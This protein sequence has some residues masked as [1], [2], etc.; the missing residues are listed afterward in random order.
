MRQTDEAPS[1]RTRQAS[2]SHIGSRRPECFNYDTLD[3]LTQAWTATDACQTNPSSNN[4]A[5]VGSGISQGAY[6]TS[7]SFDP[8]GERKAQTEH[9]LSGPGDT[10][11]NYTYDGNGAG[12]PHTL[13][14]TSTTGPAGTSTSTFSYDKTGDTT[15]RTT[16]DQGQQTLT[17]DEAGQLT[18]VTGSSNGSSYI[19]DADGNLLLQKD[20]GT[21][22][23]YL[24][25]EQLALDHRYDAVDRRSARL[26]EVAVAH[27]APNH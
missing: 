26:G 22:T 8:L 25:G 16:P 3:R 12:Q 24:P 14:K 15:Q 5:T 23:L 13:T 9:N 27:S 6:W 18:A 2:P 4:G 19:Y 17:W 1:T 10:L 7:W 21:T 20:P 11:T